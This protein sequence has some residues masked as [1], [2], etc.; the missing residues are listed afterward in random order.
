M[1]EYANK[2]KDSKSTSINSPVSQKR[3]NGVAFQL[4]D[5]RPAAVTQGKMQQAM[6]NSPHVQQL[7]TKQA[8]FNNHTSAIT[9]PVQKK[10]N[11]TGLPDNLKTG[12]E[13]LSGISMDDVKV[14]YNS[15]RPAQLQAHAY[16]QGTEIHLASGQEKHL[17]HE[18]WHVVQQK[19]GRVKATMQMK[20]GV[21][22]NNDSGLEKEADVMGQRAV[23]NLNE[24]N[25]K[26]LQLKKFDAPLKAVQRVRKEATVKWGVTHTVTAVDDS[27]F[28]SGGGLGNEERELTKGQKLFVDDEKSFVSRRGANQENAEKRMQDGAGLMKNTWLQVL[29]INGEPLENVYV[30]K[31]TI[32]LP[33]VAPV[34]MQDRKVV[35]VEEITEEGGQIES[36]LNQIKDRW[37]ALGQKRR[38]SVAQLS[39]SRAND[40]RPDKSEIEEDL[41][42]KQELCDIGLCSHP[43]WDQYNEG[44]DVAGDMQSK[45][46]RIGGNEDE[47]NILYT[48]HFTFKAYYDGDITPIAIMIIERRGDNLNDPHLYIRWMVAHPEKKGGGSKLLDKAIELLDQE[49][50]VQV[51]RLESAASAVGFYAGKGFEID[52]PAAHNGDKKCGCMEMAYKKK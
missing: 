11:N 40:L 45:D 38:Q 26:E 34:A 43:N 9:Q 20:G 48:K 25:N 19:Q 3:Q 44:D 5:N 32:T 16:A 39:L 24:K 42:D 29:E 27:L 6:N 22:L 10:A 51:I 37:V 15:A 4:I 46:D 31:E 52:K 17:P 23:V 47:E 35:K 14:H 2:L 12:V 41:E 18:A 33:P 49:A 1:S 21:N 50:D 13:N 30:R 7:K 8:V 28:G 36:G